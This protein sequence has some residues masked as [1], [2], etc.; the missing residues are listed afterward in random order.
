[1]LRPAE[2]GEGPHERHCEDHP[3]AVAIEHAQSADWITQRAAC[4]LLDRAPAV[5]LRLALIGQI[6]TKAEP[7]SPIRYNRA[8]AERIAREAPRQR[9]GA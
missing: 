8:D 5:V 9:R 6:R 3:V 4:N 1:M 2:L 7:G